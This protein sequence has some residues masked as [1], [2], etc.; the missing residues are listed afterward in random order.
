[1]SNVEKLNNILLEV[2]PFLTVAELND[3][4]DKNN[5]DG[6]DSVHQL[7]IVSSLEDT[8][9]IMLDVEDILKVDS[10]A[11]IKE[12]LIKNDVEL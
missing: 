2:F 7:S 12:I 1:M 5:V 8:F 4:L 9:D 10:Y 11:H 3:N 6:W